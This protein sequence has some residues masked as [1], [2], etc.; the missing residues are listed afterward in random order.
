MRSGKYSENEVEQIIAD[1]VRKELPDEI[2]LEIINQNFKFP[3]EVVQNMIE[4]YRKRY[5]REVMIKSTKAG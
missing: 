2:I 1:L 4:L 3:M 5:R